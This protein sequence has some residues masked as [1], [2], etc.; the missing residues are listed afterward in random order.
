MKKES[1]REKEDKYLQET[2][3][4]LKEKFSTATKVAVSSSILFKRAL[5]RILIINID[6][7]GIKNY[8]GGNAFLE[9]GFAH[10][11]S[12]KI[13]LFNPI[14]KMIYT[15]KILAMQPVILSKNLDNIKNHD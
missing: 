13:Y 5:E 1:K 12:K 11:L 6:K 15:D 3:E 9:M 8:I 4:E 10:I 7:K 2:K 14:P